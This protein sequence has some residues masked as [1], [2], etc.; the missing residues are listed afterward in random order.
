MTPGY[1]VLAVAVTALTLT[2]CTNMDGTMNR[3]ANGALIGG[4][5][6]LAL[7]RVI[8]HTD[9]SAAIGGVVGAVVGGAIGVQLADQQAE[10][11][12]SL[13]GSGAQV[14]NDGRQIHV[15]LP[16]N[17]TFPTASAVVNQGFY[18]ALNAVAQSL[19]THLNSTIRVVGHTDNV[20][21][22]AYN[23]DLSVR[24]ALAV[25]EIL[26]R[27][28]VATSRIGYLGQGFRQPVA[29]NSTSAG[30][31]ANRRVEIIIIPNP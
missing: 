30:R 21:S 7:G 4:A 22:A 20:G 10:L 27:D 31:A 29:T 9:T 2:A 25:S 23:D 12:R 14:I 15:I 24:R 16:E 6:G 1:K 17:V 5:T 3:P 8:G 11:D 28:G 13:A 19:R 26:I 18:P